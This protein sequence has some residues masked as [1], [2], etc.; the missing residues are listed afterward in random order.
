M[1]SE[2]NVKQAATF[3]IPDHEVMSEERIA[4]T[5]G[6]KLLSDLL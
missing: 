3:S 1:N 6:A 5:L 4:F 2:T